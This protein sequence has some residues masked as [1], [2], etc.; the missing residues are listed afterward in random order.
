[1]IVLL[2]YLDEVIFDL[3]QIREQFKRIKDFECSDK[4]ADFVRSCGVNFQDITIKG[5][6]WSSNWDECSNSSF[7]ENLSEIK[8]MIPK[9]RVSEK[10]CEGKKLLLETR[11][12]V[13]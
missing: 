13:K 11:K 9:E 3:M 10:I 8:T 1:M 5:D 12:M 6:H 7:I 4:I 2:Q